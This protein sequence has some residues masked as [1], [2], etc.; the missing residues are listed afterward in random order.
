MR[1]PKFVGAQQPPRNKFGNDHEA[2]S[3]NG[4]GSAP[5]MNVPGSVNRTA[6]SE[7][8]RRRNVCAEPATAAAEARNNADQQGTPQMQGR[9]GASLKACGKHLQLSAAVKAGCR[10]LDAYQR[11]QQ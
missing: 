3:V 7:Q 9:G 4:S 5:G 2:C 10:R 1:R 8:V 6:D 11:G